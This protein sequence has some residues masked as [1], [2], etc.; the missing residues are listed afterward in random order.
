MIRFLQ[1]YT[2]IS[3]IRTWRKIYRLPSYFNA[4]FKLKK[5]F[6]Q[7]AAEFS[8]ACNYP[9]LLDIDEEGGS[10]SGAYFHQDLFVAQEIFKRQPV[11]HLDIGSRIDGFV[12]HVA[13]YRPIEVMDI[14]YIT[15][16]I[17][18]I[19][20]IQKDLM[21]DDESF[22]E[23]CDSLSCL[24]VLEHFGLGRYGDTIDVDGHLKGLLNIS[25][26]LKKGGIAYISVPIGDQRIEFNAHRV[27][28]IRY[29]LDLFEKYFDIQSFSYVDDKG[30]IHKNATFTKELIDNN[31]NCHLGC[32]IFVLTKNN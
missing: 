19:T 25:K 1:H 24:H 4:Y 32:G 14:R 13:G 18:N 8:I 21:K 29:L 10:A 23:Y 16:E 5:Q 6:G 22:H 11:K 26:I 28:S 31:C 7:K 2:N 27:F 30:A 17:E 12:A 9:C 3:I 20:F 15:N